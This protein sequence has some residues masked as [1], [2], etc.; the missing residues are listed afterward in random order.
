VT[1]SIHASAIIGPNVQLGSG[2][3]VGPGVVIS[4]PCSI[5]DNNWFAPYVVIGTPGQYQGRD[6]PI[7]W[8]SGHGGQ[9]LIGS[10]NVFREFVTVHASEETVT[11]IDDDCYFMTQ[12]HIPHD[13][14]IERGVKLAN[15]VHLGGYAHV[16][17]NAYI[18]LGAVI[19]QR[20][21]IG[22][23]A[24]VGM[25]S[26]VTKH[27]PPLAKAYGSPAQV[28]GLNVAKSM[29]FELTSK[30]VE[31]LQLAYK[32]EETPSRSNLSI[33]AIRLMDEFEVNVEKLNGNIK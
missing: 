7:S 6:H 28:R 20:I 26:I 30:D 11:H 2:N 21:H 15:S 25:G 3:V 16:G 29:H 22:H 13:A 18:G 19:H 8:E 12:S 17:E 33:S 31:S 14:F 32:N 24:M 23:G 27:I 5:G 1:N 9:V 4:G 10:R